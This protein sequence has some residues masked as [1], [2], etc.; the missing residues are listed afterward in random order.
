MRTSGGA[1]REKE[2]SFKKIQ[3]QARRSQKGKRFRPSATNAKI[4]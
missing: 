2:K 4:T 3:G 1:D